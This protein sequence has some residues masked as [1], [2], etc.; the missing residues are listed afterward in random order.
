LISV[1]APSG[2]CVTVDG[3]NAGPRTPLMLAQCDDLKGQGWIPGDMAR[4]ARP[5]VQ[6]NASRVVAGAVDIAEPEY[7][8]FEGHRYCWYDDGWRG[9][10]WYWCGNS[11]NRGVGWGG[12]IGWHFWYHF[13]HRILDH[14]VIF[15]AH[16]G[17]PAH[18]HAASGANPGR[19]SQ[20]G[21]TAKDDRS[22]KG[23]QGGKS[24]AHESSKADRG[25][26]GS[27]GGT[28]A[29][30]DNSHKDSTGNSGQNSRQKDNIVAKGN[31]QSQSQSQSHNHN[32]NPGGNNH[33]GGGGHH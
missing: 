30:K 11:L 26:R 12:P 6:E 32:S 24:E 17:K 25:G 3:P 22:S 29:T 27:P 5:R 20:N 14:P 4:P 15:T 18:E 8:W 28:S 13:G 10:G 23:H 1:V 19:S 7:Y 21:K 2:L 31:N 16:H 33:G 9:P